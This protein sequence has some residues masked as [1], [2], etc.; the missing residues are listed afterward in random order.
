MDRRQEMGY[1]FVVAR[2]ECPELLELGEEVLDQVTRLVQVA[3]VRARVLAIGLGRDHR[4]LARLC[5]W[6]D[7][8]R[9]GVERLVGDQRVGRKVGQQDVGTLQIVRLPRRQRETGR[10]TERVDRGVD[11]GAQATPATPDGF[12][13]AVFFAAPALC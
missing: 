6:F 2:G 7:H 13:A 11:L 5:E 8:P 3:V 4:R 1:P 12:I 10:V 9:F